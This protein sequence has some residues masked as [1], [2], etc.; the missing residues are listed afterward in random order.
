MSATEGSESIQRGDTPILTVAATPESQ[1][2]ESGECGRGKRG[3]LFLSEYKSPQK[4]SPTDMCRWGE[5]LSQG[6]R[7]GRDR[8]ED[9]SIQIIILRLIFIA[10]LQHGVG[11]QLGRALP[12]RHGEEFLA[13]LLLRRFS[14]YV[15]SPERLAR[16]SHPL[17]MSS[18]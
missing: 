15:L 16:L 3:A 18:F 5:I 9:S 7:L 10:S 12:S 14:V 8:R 1:L 13:L 6:R 17:M 11:Q 2:P 4:V